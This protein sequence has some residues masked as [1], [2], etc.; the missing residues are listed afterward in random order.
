MSGIPRGS[1][2]QKQA[3]RAAVHVGVRLHQ[4]AEVVGRGEAAAT[5]KSMM[6]ATNQALKAIEGVWK[7]D[8]GN[9]K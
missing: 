8:A 1:P 6:D 5:Q 2:P 7:Y 3:G 4:V 9:K